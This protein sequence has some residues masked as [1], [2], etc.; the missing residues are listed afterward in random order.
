MLNG[1][2]P[3]LIFLISC[4][5]AVEIVVKHGHNGGEINCY[6]IEEQQPQGAF[7]MHYK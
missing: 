5:A 6:G 7:D 4:F 3:M 2:Y 1:G